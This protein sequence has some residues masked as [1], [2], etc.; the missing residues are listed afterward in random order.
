MRLYALILAAFLLGAAGSFAGDEPNTPNP[1]VDIEIPA[2]L[3]SAVDRAESINRKITKYEVLADKGNR[4]AERQ[5]KKYKERLNKQVEKV[6]DEIERAT[7]KDDSEIKKYEKELDRLRRRFEAAG[8]N[9]DRIA[10]LEKDIEKIEYKIDAL[11]ETGN[12]YRMFV[13]VA[14]GNFPQ[15]TP[16]ALVGLGLP[17]FEGQALGS[18]D[19]V[20]VGDLGGKP[21]I[22]VFFA[23][24][25]DD[26]MKMLR[27]ME[28]MRGRFKD[29]S[30]V[31]VSVDNNAEEV[32]DF[33]KEKKPDFPVIHDADGKI[34]QKYHVKFLPQAVLC[35][36]DGTVKLVRIGESRSVK[37][38]FRDE[39]RA[40]L[41]AADE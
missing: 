34:R 4:P 17:S 6:E 21:V 25:H 15:K 11:A 30:L 28:D 24:A 39:I 40:L 14:K 32:L 27:T 10:R 29:I 9:E 35:E 19:K 31:A 37:S 5:V 41:K 2:R 22:V 20:S 18:E 13:E 26:S 33:V 3:L 1:Y 38:V 23:T 16:F 12:A 8:D 36:P 7:K